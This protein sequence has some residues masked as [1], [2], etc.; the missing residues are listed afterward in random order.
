LIDLIRSL[1]QSREITTAA[2]L[3]EYSQCHFIL[4]RVEWI[5]VSLITRLRPNQGVLFAA[6]CS[7]PVLLAPQ[8]RH[9]EVGMS[10]LLVASATAVGRDVSL[11]MRL[12]GALTP[13]NQ[14]V[15]SRERA[16]YEALS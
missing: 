16:N 14:V 11:S 15:L 4:S 6:T 2:S 5:D 3:V 10:P 7:P 8:L 1:H 9:S 13:T 12:T